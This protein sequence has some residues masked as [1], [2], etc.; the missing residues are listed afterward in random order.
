MNRGRPR[1]NPVENNLQSNLVSDSINETVSNSP[2]QVHQSN[3]SNR[4]ATPLVGTP[5]NDDTRAQRPK[6][7]PMGSQKRL[8]APERPGFV[9]RYFNDV[10]DRIERAKL[11]GYTPVEEEIVYSERSK[12]PTVLGKQ[13]RVSVGKGTYAVLMEIPEEWYCEDQLA[14]VKNNNEKVR[15]LRTPKKDQYGS[16]PNVAFTMEERVT[17]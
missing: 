4:P 5:L 17:G 10:D 1:K 2:S 3:L 14:K 16:T 13:R 9:R 6:R 7:V 12:D 15:S 11:A 8:S